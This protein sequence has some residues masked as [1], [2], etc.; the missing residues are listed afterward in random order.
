MDGKGKY[1]WKSHESFKVYDGQYADHMRDGMGTMLYANGDKWKGRWI[2][3]KRHG[4]G[5]LS[6][7]DEK[8]NKKVIKGRWKDE[9]LVVVG[10][11]K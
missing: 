1:T 3:D 9:E 10:K 8:G 7:R 6:T 5:E 4:N 11:D 2:E